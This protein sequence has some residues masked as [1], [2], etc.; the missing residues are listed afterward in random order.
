VKLFV[1]VAIS[2]LALGCATAPAAGGEEKMQMRKIASGSYAATESVDPQAFIALDDATYVRAWDAMIGGTERP[3][4]DFAT[5]SVVFLLG[6]RR[7]TG[8]WSIDVQNVAI[9]GDALVV[10]ANIKSPPSGS[11]VTQALTF[12]WTVV[13]V[14]NRTAKRVKWDRA[15]EHPEG[16]VAQ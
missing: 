11:I 12:P 7:S 16:P 8:G 9:V 13:A 15:P 4:V 6:G 14:K 1:V 3:A 5:E 10:D 2:L